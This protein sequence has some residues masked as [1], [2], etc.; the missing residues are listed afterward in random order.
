M[1]T[2]QRPITKNR[3]SLDILFVLK[4]FYL[5]A[6]TKVLHRKLLSVASIPILRALPVVRGANGAASI[7]SDARILGTLYI[8]FDDPGSP[9]RLTIG[10]NF[11]AEANVTISPR[12]GEVRIGNDCFVGKNATIQAVAGSFIRIGN[13]VMIAD[14]VT[15]MASN[16]NVDD[17]STPMKRLPELGVGITIESD[18]WIAAHAVVLD[19]VNIGRGA[20]IAAGA[21]V[22]RDVPPY[23]IVAGVPARGIGSRL[24]RSTANS[25][26]NVNFIQT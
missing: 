9:G 4:S 23:A 16:H 2:S 21:V 24:D 26:H 13:D 20:V 15:V 8:T 1:T 14:T 25:T 11:I 7:G 22:T 19:G 10:K 18:V 17:V 5:W 3:N 12:G 6:L